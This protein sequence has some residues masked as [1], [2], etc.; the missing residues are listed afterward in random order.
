M[1]NS[2]CPYSPNSCIEAAI[3]DLDL[4]NSMRALESEP[5][6]GVDSSFDALME[7]LACKIQGEDQ[8]VGHYAAEIETTVLN[9]L[10]QHPDQ[11][12]EDTMVHLKRDIFYNGLR[13]VY[14]ESFIYMYEDKKSFEQILDAVLIVEK[15]VQKLPTKKEPE[16]CNSPSQEELRRKTRLKAMQIWGWARTGLKPEIVVYVNNQPH[17]AILDLGS[18]VSLIDQEITDD[19]AVT[20]HSFICDVPQSVSLRCRELNVAVSNVIG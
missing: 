8:A 6:E 1:S 2:P 17:D 20:V 12:D 13:R 3:Q 18:D 10:H 15:A 9:I 16:K 11:M 7:K 19:L 14:R 4:E 5:K